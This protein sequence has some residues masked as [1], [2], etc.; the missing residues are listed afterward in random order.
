MKRKPLRTQG[1]QNLKQLI[2]SLIG[3]SYCP[4]CLKEIPQVD[5][6]P[7]FHVEGC[8]NAPPLY[9]ERW[10]KATGRTWPKEQ[11]VL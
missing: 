6:C 4:L 10:E 9:I 3:P 1:E 7:F 5:P 11:G 2:Y 8:L